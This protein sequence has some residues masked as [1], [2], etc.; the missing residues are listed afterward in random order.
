MG[1]NG[2]CVGSCG[3]AAV[4]AVGSASIGGALVMAGG[5][6]STGGAARRG[7]GRG[8]AAW[9]GSASVMWST[10]APD[11]TTTTRQM[12]SVNT[13]RARLPAP[14]W[15]PGPGTGP[16]GGRGRRFRRGAVALTLTLV[17]GLAASRVSLPLVAVAPGS[18]VEVSPL[19]EVTGAPSFAPEG[20][21][22]LLTV[23][24][25]PLTLAGALRGWVDPTVEVV[26]RDRVLPADAREEEVRD[27]DLAQMDSSKEQAL[28]VAF[29]E[30]G[31]DAVSGTGAEVV[32]VEAGSAADGIL[33][34]GDVI[35][36]L[37][38]AP[39]ATHHDVVSA[40]RRRPP[41]ARA[42]VEI[43]PGGR[44]ERRLVGLTL[45]GGA[46]DP[47]AGVLGVTLR[48]R[49]ARFD[50]PFPVGIDSARI[51][52]PSAGLAF[53]L[54]VLDVLTEGSLTGGRRVAATGTMGLD[55]SVGPVGGVA[56]KTAVALEEGVEL[57]LVPAGEAGEAR[58]LAGDDLNVEAV[59]NLSE[60]LRALVDHGGEPLPRCAGPCICPSGPGGACR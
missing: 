60:A 22:Y 34:A 26:A 47:A 32:Q 50:F 31:Y 15:P 28:G 52:G 45:A 49:Q 16:H 41:G 46:D 14:A 36:G 6:T 20:E 2:A 17:L 11:T 18:A 21:I 1:G 33:A 30:L 42:E 7:R 25:R 5:S 38:G 44:G 13:A 58:R 37:D 48:T 53:T 40:L 56:Q 57:F 59:G 10:A 27:L 55:G 3:A 54:E 24:L 8:V 39:V 43:D 29:E 51:G 4:T 23:R 19:V 12:T 9:V 35:V